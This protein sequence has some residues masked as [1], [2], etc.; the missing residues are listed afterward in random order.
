MTTL[1]LLTLV[2]H[3]PA[4][5]LNSMVVWCF[6]VIAIGMTVL[7]NDLLLMLLVGVLCVLQ[8]DTL[9]TA[10]F[11]LHPQ[12]GQLSPD[13][14]TASP[15]SV[16]QRLVLLLMVTL[17]MAAVVY[18]MQ[19]LV[20][21]TGEDALTG[22]PNRLWLQLGLP[23]LLSALRHER[24]LGVV[25]TAADRPLRASGR[26]PRTARRRRAAAATGHPV[27][28]DAARRRAPGAAVAR[29][30]RAGAAGAPG[31]RLGAHRTP[32]CRHA[33]ERNGDGRRSGGSPDSGQ[34]RSGRLAA[35][36]HRCDQPAAQGR[37]LSADRPATRRRLRGGAHRLSGRQLPGIGA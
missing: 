9:A 17:L 14:G 37:C 32:A 16:I 26:R 33:C 8:F 1:V 20:Q 36:R 11:A 29:R 10:V 25:G 12:A 22:L 23:Q 24:N 7:R 5:G 13:Y 6:Y 4:A 3:E 35:G 31:R 28:A 2:W 18:R 15:S 27:A 19:R 30:V 34:C 21:L